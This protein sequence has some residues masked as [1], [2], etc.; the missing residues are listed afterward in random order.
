MRGTIVVSRAV[1]GSVE[2][3]GALEGKVVEALWRCQGAWASVGDTVDDL[4]AI[5]KPRQWAYNSVMTVMGRLADKALCCAVA[6]GGATSSGPR[7]IKEQWPE[8]EAS[9]ALLDILD[10]YVQ[11]AAAGIAMSLRDRSELAAAVRRA[12]DEEV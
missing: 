4:S 5:Y 12:L 7:S 6:R 11:P 10:V 3:P 2:T 1:K 8:Y 9:Q